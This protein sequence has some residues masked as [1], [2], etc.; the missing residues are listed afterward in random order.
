M[1]VK[2]TEKIKKTRDVKNNKKC[3]KYILR[4]AG[5]TRSYHRNLSN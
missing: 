2:V 3:K 5:N 4:G 1:V